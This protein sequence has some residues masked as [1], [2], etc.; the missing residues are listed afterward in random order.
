MSADE[1]FDVVTRI[2]VDPKGSAPGIAAVQRQ[3]GMLD[4]QIQGVGTQLSNTLRNAAGL[5]GAAV[6]FRAGQG[7]VS[8]IVGINTAAQNAEIGIAGLFAAM[9]KTSVP[10]QLG[11]ARAVFAQL[12][13][14]A[15]AGAGDTQD[16]V[17]AYQRILGP[18]KAAGATMEQI[19]EMTRLGLGA[20]FALRGEQGLKV[21]GMDIVQGLLG[22]LSPAES[23]VLAPLLGIAGSSLQQLNKAGPEEKV[24]IIL[25]ALRAMDPAVKAMGGTWD[26][27]FSTLKDNAKQLIASASAPIFQRWLEHLRHVNEWMTANKDLMFEYAEKWGR[28]AV[29]VWDQILSRAREIA[30]LTAG[31]GVVGL[32]G[33]SGLPSV[34]GTVIGGAG[35]GGSA[36]AA[37]VLALLA[38]QGLAVHEAFQTHPKLWT[39][40]TTQARA[41][42]RSAQSLLTGLRALEPAVAAGSP[43]RFAFDSFGVGL[44]TMG[45]G[46]LTMATHAVT[47]TDGVTRFGGAV[48][49][50]ATE[51]LPAAL[52]AL[53]GYGTPGSAN[54]ILDS[55]IIGAFEG[56]EKG[57]GMGMSPFRGGGMAMGG[58]RGPAEWQGPVRTFANAL[59][60]AGLV[61]NIGRAHK[62][63]PIKPV[64]NVTI[65][66]EQAQDPHRVAV[67][68]KDVLSNAAKWQTAARKSLEAR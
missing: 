40:I 20:G 5:L 25:K 11:N 60:H 46:Y 58:M 10:A 1:T 8:Q 22:G 50:L 6:A 42:E 66:V 52:K 63:Q 31:A 44:A 53:A 17:D 54:R 55:A 37:G 68:L 4:R 21:A 45:Q 7:I 30:K 67:A 51:W 27:Q 38:V 19:R 3:I 13:A 61:G 12:R 48:F 59:E 47:A 28:R 33:R 64:V 43:L 35:I 34:A 23:Q 49:R 39:Q 56:V 16:Y 9:S 18:A 41:L 29:D 2:V 62:P 26:A 65:N 15:A 14:D 24:Q 36:A 32:A 57:P